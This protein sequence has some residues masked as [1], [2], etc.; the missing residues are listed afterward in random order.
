MGKQFEEIPPEDLFSEDPS[1]RAET[2]FATLQLTN[3]RLR[4]AWRHTDSSVAVEYIKGGGN[5][6]YAQLGYSS[7]EQ[8]DSGPWEWIDPNQRRF[9][10]FDASVQCHNTLGWLDVQGEGIYRTPLLGTAGNPPCD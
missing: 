4:V 7:H 6:I 1:V 5:R 9:Y 2:H 3:G 10:W 8:S